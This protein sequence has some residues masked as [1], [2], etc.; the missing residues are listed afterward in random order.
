MIACERLIKLSFADD[1]KKYLSLLEAIKQKI[2]LQSAFT[3][4]SKANL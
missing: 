4:K 3:I 1:Y 2:A